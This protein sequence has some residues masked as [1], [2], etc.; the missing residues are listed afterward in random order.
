MSVTVPR[1]KLRK[2]ETLA[3]QLALQGSA[4]LK[5]IQSALGYFNHISQAIGPAKAFTRRI[6][7]VVKEAKSNPRKASR[8]NLDRG[9]RLDLKFWEKYAHEFNGTA[10]ILEKPIMTKGL[11]ATDATE[12]PNL[13]MG[14]FY[15][16]KPFSVRWKDLPKHRTRYGLPE[17][18]R[19]W[20]AKKLWPDPRHS[21]DPTLHTHERARAHINY[22][23]MFAV[24]WALL[25]WTGDFGNKRVT[26][27]CDNTTAE[28]CLNRLR[29]T[30]NKWMMR[31]VRH[32]ARFCAVHNISLHITRITSKANE[33]ADALSRF[34]RIRYERALAAWLATDKITWQPRWQERTFRDPPLLEQ[35]A[36]EYR[37]DLL[38]HGRDITTGA[39]E[40]VEG[41][42]DLELPF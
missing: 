24:W 10:V 35:Q 30:K 34:D 9:A 12:D 11:L 33:L 29:A 3:A 40:G 27:H 15:N 16:G 36:A 20:N 31:L 6:I 7:D 19:A 39:K 17:A 38:Q 32:I 5:Q 41:E 8:V 18:S 37:P 4:T 42:F 28:G 26:L 25:T 21:R 22:K 1:E 14:G 2:A 23:E 13:G